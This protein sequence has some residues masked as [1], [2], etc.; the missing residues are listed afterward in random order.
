M[1]CNTLDCAEYYNFES[2]QLVMNQFVTY[3]LCL[4]VCL[5][6][7]SC[8]RESIA[9]ESSNR[10]VVTG[11]IFD[12]A[13]SL[14]VPSIVI[15]KMS[16][17][18]EKE[19]LEIS[20][21]GY[22]YYTT[23]SKRN[24]DAGLLYHGY[25]SLIL[26]PGDSLHVTIVGEDSL[27]FSGD[28]SRANQ[29]AR[30][31]FNELDTVQAAYE[32]LWERMMVLDPEVYFEI[33]DSLDQVSQT[34]V[35]KFVT[36]Y[37]IEDV[38]LVRWLKNQSRDSYYSYLSIYIFRNRDKDLDQ[39]RK[40][41]DDRLP[42]SES[43]MSNVTAMNSFANYYPNTH[44]YHA[45]QDTLE[46]GK[47]VTDTMMMRAMLDFDRDPVLREMMIVQTVN[48]RLDQFETKLYELNREEINSVISDS[49]LRDILRQKYEEVQRQMDITFDSSAPIFS[50]S[51]FS[52]TVLID[53]IIDANKGNVVYIDLWATWCGPCISELT[54]QGPF[55]KKLEGRP[56]T[57]VYVCAQSKK[58]RVW[59]AM[60]SKFHIASSI[61]L[62]LNK[63]QFKEFDERYDV[64]GFPTYYMYDK[65]GTLVES[66][67]NWRPSNPNTLDR[68]NEL[69]NQ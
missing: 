13:D 31:L 30:G 24:I 67:H 1:G 19:E 62:F 42:L 15:H 9:D 66:G 57:F 39:I 47:R 64:K 52:A 51:V 7:V 23:E 49:E 44:L 33:V 68:L 65:E 40:A 53:S 20:D 8:N 22:F 54:N 50:D 5:A 12:Y 28:R 18:Q 43:D 37:D 60:L 69:M 45:I 16:L 56:M 29:L 3:C 32:P 55:K 10:I 36:D 58:E 14:G 34:I 11:Q 4:S 59:K 38:D 6:L 21:S 17:G 48:H 2:K 41:I 25:H 26:H 27:L 35:N 46:E 61:N 63:E